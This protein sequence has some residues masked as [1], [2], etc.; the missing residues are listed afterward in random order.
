MYYTYA[1]VWHDPPSNNWFGFQCWGLQRLADLFLEVSDKNT[2][3]ANAVRPNCEIILNKFVNYVLN[4]VQL[5]STDDFSLPDTLSWVSNTQVS[6][7]TTTSANLEGVYE[8]LPSLTWDGTGDYGAF[9][10]ESTVPNPNLHC[11]IAVRGNDLGVASSLA[12]LLNLFAQAKRNM[13]KF[14]T[15]LTGSSHTPEDAFNLA[16]ELLDRIWNGPHRDTKGIAHP[17]QRGDYKRMGDTIYI[18]S[19]FVGAHMANNDPITPGSATFTSIRSFITHQSDWPQIA[20]YIADPVNAPAPT[21]TYHRYWANAEYA[22]ACGAM[23]HY[24]GD[25]VYA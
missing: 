22:M 14:T 23:H 15:A 1:P 3:V 10:N 24:F 16:K 21:F 7:Q 4:Q 12:L 11:S 2:T 19:N 13:N 6:G 20:A 18:P 25:I 17:E 8:Y 5:V 9:W